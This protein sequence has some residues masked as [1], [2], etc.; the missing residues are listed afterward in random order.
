MERTKLFISY[1][2]DD[3]AWLARLAV[4]LGVLERRG[5]VELWSDE[6]IRIGAKWLTEIKRALG[7]AKIAVLL[8]SPSFLA[9]KFVWDEEMPHIRKHESLGMEVFPFI[10][11]PCAWL[12]EPDLARLQARPTDGRPLSLGSD[13]QV[14]S[15]L[16]IFVYELAGRIMELNGAAV[17]KELDR[18]D[19]YRSDTRILGRGA[20]ASSKLEQRSATF[21][22]VTQGIRL[23]SEWLGL[24][25]KRLVIR[26]RITSING[27]DFLARMEY[28][29]ERATTVTIVEGE[30]VSDAARAEEWA[31]LNASDGAIRLRFHETDYEIKGSKSVRFDGEYRAVLAGDT[32]RGAWFQGAT[33]VAEFKLQANRTVE[34]G[35]PE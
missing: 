17:A 15:D 18:Y 4:H 28:P 23:Q 19:D 6:R 1:S 14:D 7:E 2:H 12:L 9:S 29:S 21:G 5:R 13:S 22:A 27:D 30:V 10:V 32:M 35:E 20:L 26:L 33:M 11:R 3:R 25:D 8:V 31:K 16:A 34:G 24:Y